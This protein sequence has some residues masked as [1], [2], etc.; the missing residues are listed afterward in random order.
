M[1]YSVNSIYHC[2]ANDRKNTIYFEIRKETEG[3]S[4]EWSN[5]SGFLHVFL[6]NPE[7]LLCAQIVSQADRGKRIIGKEIEKCD[8]ACRPCDSFCGLWRLEYGIVFERG[9]G[10]LEFRINQEE[11][12]PVRKEEFRLDANSGTIT[13][14]EKSERKWFAGDFHTHTIFSDGQMS[15]EEN[16]QMAKRQGLDYYCPTDHNVLHYMWPNTGLTIIPGAEITSSFGHAN[17]LFAERTPFESHS[18]SEL[19]SEDGVLQIL[20]EAES[21]ALVCVVHPFMKHW[22]FI[23]GDFPLEKLKFMEIIND[24]TYITAQESAEKALLAWNILLNDGYKITAVGGSDS[25]IKPDSKYPYAEEGSLL[26]DP[27]T[28]IY[29]KNQDVQ[30][31]KAGL[32]RGNVAVSRKGRIEFGSDDAVSGDCIESKESTGFYARVSEKTHLDKKLEIHWILDGETYK[33]VKDNESNI[34]L[35]LDGNYHWV[36]VDIRDEEGFLYGFSNPIFINDM[37]KIHQLEKWK[38]L[39]DLIIEG[40]S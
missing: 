8:P 10:P 35:K 25:H 18:I 33:V 31:L 20:T 30:S 28:F 4:L 34:N 15:R 17:L 6:Y 36:R 1:L 2:L 3:I 29:A 9:E 38:D 19:E 32:I 16:N 12:M 23:V 26:G 21:Y 40:N 13:G 39:K 11:D 7:G 37:P 14:D 24:P 5:N 22:D 27:K